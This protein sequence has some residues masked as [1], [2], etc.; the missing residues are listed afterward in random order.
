MNEPQPIIEPRMNRVTTAVIYGWP[1]RFWLICMLIVVWVGH[2]Y[3]LG[4]WPSPFKLW[5]CS[6]IGAVAILYSIFRR[7]PGLR[8]ISQ[9]GRKVI[10]PI[11]ALGVVGIGMAVAIFFTWVAFGPD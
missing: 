7:G 5:I 9:Q 1:L 4:T 2:F 10:S 11:Q 3:L 6:A 8:A